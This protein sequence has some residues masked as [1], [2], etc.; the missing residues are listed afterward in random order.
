M[1][2][3]HEPVSARD[4][5]W[6]SVYRQLAVY[7]LGS[8]MN[9]GFV[10]AYFRSFASPAIAAVLDRTGEIR[11]RPAKRSTDTGI[12][13]YEIIVNGFDSARGARMVE[14]L[15]RVHRGVPGSDDD[16]LYVLL[17]LLVVPVRWIE[18]HGWRNMTGAERDAAH[19]FYAELGR[20]M[21]L[22]R[23]PRGYDEAAAAFDEYEAA[24]VAWSPAAGR[25]TDSTMPAFTGRLPAW[26]KRHDR[27]V[28]STLLADLRVSDALGL[29]RPSRLVARVTGLVLRARKARGRAS[30]APAFTPGRATTVYPFG[31]GLSDIGPR[32]QRR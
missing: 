31:Y 19:R 13:V 27:A 26:A 14:L 21:G 29:P 11:E 1:T 4:D 3:A 25:L 23:I 6:E 32:P 28:L 20:R 30:T 2:P 10:L 5:G 7:D 24:H 9:V 18:A 8:D 22:R 12:I 16:F 17:S 15:C